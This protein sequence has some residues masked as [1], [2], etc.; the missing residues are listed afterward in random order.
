MT[1]KT[2]PKALILERAKAR[3]GSKRRVIFPPTSEQR[4]LSL[5][6]LRFELAKE[7]T[8]ASVACHSQMKVALRVLE[9]SVDE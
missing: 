4:K 6:R 3:V 9:K 2:D 1:T 8:I 7:R 5:D